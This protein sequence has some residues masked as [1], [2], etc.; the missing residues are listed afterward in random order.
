MKL[1]HTITSLSLLTLSF[2][3][4]AAEDDNEKPV[5]LDELPAAVVKAI[6]DATGDAKIT[7]LVREKDDDVEAIEATWEVKGKRHEVVVGLD[8]KVLCK[9]EVIDLADA[10]EPIRAAIAKAANGKKVKQVEKGVEKGK[11]FYEAQIA[12]DKG[13]LEVKLDAT[14][15]ELEREEGDDEKD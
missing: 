2:G 9:E 3:A 14:G 1:I 5:K 12:T 4:F 15:K 6:K 7:N 13:T 11:T 10:P 8:G